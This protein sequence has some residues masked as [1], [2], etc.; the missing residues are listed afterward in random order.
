MDWIDRGG[1][2]DVSKAMTTT[3]FHFSVD[4]IDFLVVPKE[5]AV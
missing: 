3:S 5:H 1:T 2:R 4:R